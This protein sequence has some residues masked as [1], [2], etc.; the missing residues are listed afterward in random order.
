MTQRLIYIKIIFIPI[1]IGLLLAA[2]TNVFAA[3][4]L[5]IVTSSEYGPFEYWHEGYG[6][7]GVIW[8][9]SS[10]TPLPFEAGSTLQFN[11]SNMILP[12]KFYNFIRAIDLNNQN[13][14][15]LV[16]KNSST[17]TLGSIIDSSG[18][19]KTDI[20]LQDDSS[21][22]L[23]GDRGDDLGIKT[24]DNNYTG[25][26]NIQFV[27]TKN[28][29]TINSTSK[30][31]TIFNGKFIK[32]DGTKANLD[33]QTNFTVTDPSINLLDAIRIRPVPDD[34]A[35]IIFTIDVGAT[36]NLDLLQNSSSIEL[37]HQ[38]SVLKL[39]HDKGGQHTVTFHQNLVGQGALE[40]NSTGQDSILTVK[41]KDNSVALGKENSKL[42]ELKVTTG[43]IV[44]LKVFATNIKLNSEA[45]SADN[46]SISFK[47]NINGNITFNNALTLNMLADTKGDIDFASNDGIL[48][49]G[50]NQTIDGNVDNSKK[51][52]GI[53]NYTGN[54]IVTGPIGGTYPLSQLKFSGPGN[55]NLPVAHV[56]T[57]D[58]G[59]ADV[60]ITATDSIT[61]KVTYSAAGTLT[62]NNG[63]EGDIDFASN[64]GTLNLANG[65][66]IKGNVDSSTGVGGIL[67]YHGS[68]T[69]TGTIGDKH[70]LSQLKFSGA[71]AMNLPV[72]NVKA[73]NI[74]H[75]D[76]RITAS[77]LITGQVIYSAPGTLMA[78][79]GIVG[80][81]DFKGQAGKLSLANNQKIEGNVVSS[82]SSNGTIAFLGAGTI[83]GTIG[84]AIGSTN[85]LAQLQFQGPGTVN[86]PAS[87]VETYNIAHA[88]SHVI[89]NGLIIGNVAYNEPGALTANNGIVG[90]VDFKGQAGKLSLANNQKIEGNVISS[91]SSNGTIAF[92]GTA[93]V[94]G[95]I[96][97]AIGST[98]KL[99]QLQFQGP[100]TV[101]LPASNVETYN[102]AH[103]D[104]HVIANGLIIG[105]VAYNEPGA[106]TANNG[107]VGDV[108][109]KGQAGKLN[110]A[111]NQKIEGNVISSDGSNGT[112][113]FLGAGTV[114]GI[115]GGATKLAQLQFQGPG[116]INLPASNVETYN[117]AH[118]EAHVTAPALVTGKVIYSAAGTLTA[119]NGI[120][121]DV[122]FKGQAGKLSLANNQK[123]EGNVVS[124]DGSNGTIAFLGTGTVTGIIGG[125]TKLAQLQ[126]QG[127]GT[128]NLPASNVDTYN[129]AH[130]DSHVI[131]PELITGDITYSAA[132]TL[133][134]NNGIVGN[135]DFKGQAGKLSLANNQKIEG[136]V[137]SSDGS[138]GTI[139]FL[140]T[141]TVT[142]IIGGATK[143]AQLQ[144]QGPGTVNLPASNV[145]TY[146]IAHADSHVIA[147]E[148][149]TGDITY[150]AAGTLTANNGI[151]GNIDFKGQA[152]KLS[153]A[154]NQKIE[155]NVVSSDGSNGTIAFLGTG[156]VTGIIGGATKLA[157]L[158][159]QGPGTVNLPASN[160]DTY[161]IAHADSHVIAP[162]LITG[163]ITYSAAGTL[164]VNNGIVGDIDF[165]SQAGTINLA[166][167]QTIDGN[168]DSSTGVGGIL[169]YH[170]NGIVTGNIGSSDAIDKMNIKDGLV[171]FQGIVKSNNIIIS[172]D[173]IAEFN[174]DITVSDI[175]GDIANAGTIRLR[176]TIPATI[177]GAVGNINA[178]NTL[179]IAGQDL[180]ITDKVNSNNISF[181]NLQLPVL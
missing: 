36:S 152:G 130:A 43:N 28:S 30:T 66:T 25:V 154:N 68:G 174:K 179:E 33:V 7:D 168:V 163:D 80:D 64:D 113:A 78:N 111:N 89:A 3:P 86:L 53:L 32:Q 133:T 124:S 70:K 167:G 79:K 116:I 44:D 132:G 90:D 15:Q 107:I 156:T 22:V 47:Q 110:L 84:G 150:S 181:T 128:V 138:N 164:T 4:K 144:L 73:Y 67:N 11:T 169:N 157:Q 178:I 40:L 75:D 176:N 10:P 1:T 105:N 112:I 177:T 170:G 2:S 121:G 127:P 149:I 56:L 106:L 45:K 103:A 119:N 109:F 62:A 171:Q 117:I 71:G 77:G 94:T 136:N 54:G 172:T 85:K 59:H 58:I 100:G 162:E 8:G 34:T 175:T 74:A 76:A 24:G 51:A 123:I 153:L 155:G 81:I 101:N 148:L 165:G 147:P 42:D 98:N 161:N 88:D 146:N 41:G 23:S 151:V 140:G 143:L 180:I 99:A 17:N 129:I 57:Y 21:V 114:T 104:S 14:I 166:D 50:A 97:G 5:R 120:V 135:I 158:Q 131:A 141:G 26:N 82:D 13:N 18:Q 96:G 29:L 20:I 69:V 72:A 92:L 9:Y 102:I 6:L 93:T 12:V 48:N 125:A 16:I 49:L 63:I 37:D 142:G 134:A 60:Y 65:K 122:D 145:D 55:I 118:S 27:G 39:Q 19:Q 35:P 31:E 108:D 46:S 137:V 126:L 61:G 160:V 52:G 115:I 38:N 159:L 87:N 139:A 83:T 91:D 173:A 95:T